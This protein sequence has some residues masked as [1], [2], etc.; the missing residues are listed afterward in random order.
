MLLALE[1]GIETDIE[2]TCGGLGR[3]LTGRDRRRLWR[4][5][6]QWEASRSQK[7]AT[8]RLGGNAAKW[9]GEAAKRTQQGGDALKDQNP[10]GRG[11]ALEVKETITGM[12]EQDGHAEHCA[13]LGG[14]N[15]RAMGVAKCVTTE[16]GAEGAEHGPALTTVERIPE[17]V[18]DAALHEPCSGC[19][20]PCSGSGE[21]WEQAR[22][23]VNGA[24]AEW[25][26]ERAGHGSALTVAEGILGRV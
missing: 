5:L 6:R 8:W 1:P 18:R 10:V 24:T 22:G 13:S 20:M 21:E 17:R 26:A 3:P 15:G 2:A 9:V 14:E 25:G 16:W 7:T 11:K 4:K 19:A 23:V 12:A